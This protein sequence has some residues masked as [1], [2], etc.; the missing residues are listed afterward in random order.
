MPIED[1]I[2]KVNA[3][4]DL[5]AGINL[6]F[7][8]KY[9]ISSIKVKNILEKL[10]TKYDIIII[11]TSSECFLNYTKEMMKLCQINIFILEANLLEIKKAQRLLNIYINEWQIPQKNFKMIFNKYNKNAIDDSILKH[12]FSDFLILGKLSSNS[13]YDQIINKNAIGLFHPKIQKEYRKIQEKILEK[14][15]KENRQKKKVFSKK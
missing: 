2:I 5:I 14:M 4:I 6:L 1:L 9:Q 3:K 10:K 12:I 13:Q 11:D 15:G 8:S 7:D